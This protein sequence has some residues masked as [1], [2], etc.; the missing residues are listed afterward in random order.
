MK[1]IQ[2]VYDSGSEEPKLHRTVV[3]DEYVNFVNDC[4]AAKTMCDLRSTH[5]MLIRLNFPSP[6]IAVV[7]E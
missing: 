5:E 1:V 3:C 6:S 4:T 7:L 2:H